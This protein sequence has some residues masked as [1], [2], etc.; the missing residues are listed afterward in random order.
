MLNDKSSIVEIEDHEIEIVNGGN[1]G[2]L[3]VTVVIAA[4]AGAWKVGSALAE[5]QNAYQCSVR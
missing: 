3:V 1:L 4:A 5:R 2:S